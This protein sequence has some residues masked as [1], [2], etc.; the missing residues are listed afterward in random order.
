MKIGTTY[1]DLKSVQ[2]IKTKQDAAKAF[3][4]EFILMFLK[5]ARKSIKPGFL[6]NS[7]SSKLYFDMFDMQIAHEI[8]KSDALGIGEYIQNALESYKKNSDG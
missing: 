1:W 5:E 8:A 6:D 3:E 2:N 7:F 4:E